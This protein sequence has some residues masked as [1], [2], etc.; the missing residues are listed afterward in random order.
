LFRAIWTIT[1]RQRHEYY[2][3]SEAVDIST[4]ENFKISDHSVL[5]LEI[6]LKETIH[7]AEQCTIEENSTFVKF[8]RSNIPDIFLNDHDTDTHIK[9]FD[10]QCLNE[11]ITITEVENA[12]K[13]LNKNKVVGHDNVPATTIQICPAPI[14]N[15]SCFVLV[16]H[17]KKCRTRGPLVLSLSC[18]KNHPQTKV[19]QSVTAELQWPPAL[20]KVYCSVLNN[21][22]VKSCERN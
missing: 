19:I 14:A 6:K 10:W 1:L 13:S 15:T 9:I 22:P 4:N 2:K 20:Y 16:L 21:R 5:T 7:L 17:Q 11:G 8:N 12:V 18:L 3:N